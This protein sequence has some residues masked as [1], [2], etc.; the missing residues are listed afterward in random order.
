MVKMK[1]EFK[2]LQESIGL[3]QTP[4]QEF[5]KKASEELLQKKQKL[6]EERI[7]EKTGLDIDLLMEAAARFPRLKCEINEGYVYEKWYWNDGSK[8][9]ILLIT[10]CNNQLSNEINADKKFSV[11]FSYR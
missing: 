2:K 8:F 4:M 5:I 7:K 1:E 3:I 10:F 6:V 9:G 11:G